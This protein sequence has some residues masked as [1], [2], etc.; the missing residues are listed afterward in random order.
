M[1]Y[2]LRWCL[3][4]RA[5]EPWQLRG[6]RVGLHIT[7]CCLPRRSLRSFYPLR[8][9][10]RRR[11]DEPWQLRGVRVGLSERGGMRGRTLLSKRGR[12]VCRRLRRY[13]P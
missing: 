13:L 7:M 1:F 6:V 2:P 11:A 8:R 3:R 12:R 5:D 9:C 4:R 10:L